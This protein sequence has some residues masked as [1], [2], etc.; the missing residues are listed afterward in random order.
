MKYIYK[1]A[2]YYSTDHDKHSVFVESDIE[3]H[4]L[5]KILGAI[6]FKFEELIDESDCI[7]ERHLVSILEKFFGMKNITDEC[8]KYL[9]ETQLEDTEWETINE[10]IFL[11]SEI[12]KTVQVIQIDQYR[13]R[14]C[15]CGPGYKDLMRK[16]LPST[17]DFEDEIK[18]IQNFYP[19]LSNL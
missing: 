16:Y 15:C 13:A 2:H 18:N 12:H 14:E 5:V 10:F 17:I 7:E 1:I 19:H 11:D 8:Q 6:Q 9:P 4:T 3:K